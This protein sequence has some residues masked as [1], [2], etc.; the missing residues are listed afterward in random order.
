MIKINYKQ[1]ISLLQSG[2]TTINTAIDEYHR[3]RE[4]AAINLGYNYGKIMT[5]QTVFLLLILVAISNCSPRITITRD[6]DDQARFSQYKTF[7]WG[8]MEEDRHEEFP[9]YDNSLNRKRIKQAVSNELVKIGYV[10]NENEPD[11]IVDFHILVESK[12]DFT[13]HSDRPYRYWRDY[14]LSTYNYKVGTL[15]IHIIDPKIDQ[16]VWQGTASG[17]LDE[18]PTEV[19]ERINAVVAKIFEKFP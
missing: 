11:L 12:Q 5:F 8:P 15:I 4:N 2:V 19:E 16:L 18:K 17:V 7:D 9:M 10:L 1:C 13:T 6:S 14:Q 3:V